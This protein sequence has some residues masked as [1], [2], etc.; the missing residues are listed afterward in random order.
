[1]WP[2]IIAW[3]LS[4]ILENSGNSPDLGH[5]AWFHNDNYFA[6][7]PVVKYSNGILYLTAL[8][9]LSSH[10]AARAAWWGEKHRIHPPTMTVCFT[11]NKS[12]ACSLLGTFLPTWQLF[13]S[14]LNHS[15][16]ILSMFYNSNYTMLKEA[17]THVAQKGSDLN[18]GWTLW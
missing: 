12:A 3:K 13:V 4:S 5:I 11:D 10:R 2:S 7:V 14:V 6:Y 18:C 9:F 16:K 8:L 17:K 15:S 1:M